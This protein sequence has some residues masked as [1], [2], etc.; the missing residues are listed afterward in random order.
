[1]KRVKVGHLVLFCAGNL[2]RKLASSFWSLLVNGLR[3]KSS[4]VQSVSTVLVRNPPIKAGWS[5][6][7]QLTLLQP[8]AYSN[9]KVEGK[10]QRD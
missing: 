7:V 8:L 10:F 6:W 4:H 3:L 9:G 5:V 2:A 1:M